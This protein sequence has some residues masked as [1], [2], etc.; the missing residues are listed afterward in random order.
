MAQPPSPDGRLVYLH[1]S[2]IFSG[3]NAKIRKA[4]KIAQLLEEH[5]VTIKILTDESS[6]PAIAAVAKELLEQGMYESWDRARLRYPE[7]FRPSETQEA[8]RAASEAEVVR[9]EAVAAHEKAL[10][11][12]DEEGDECPYLEKGEKVDEPKARPNAK[13]EPNDTAGTKAADVGRVTKF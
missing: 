6:L 5:Q 8:E 1:C 4:K 13:V 10:T 12:E 2:T 7:L 11:S 3:Q 9:I